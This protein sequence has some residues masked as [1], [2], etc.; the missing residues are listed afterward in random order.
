MISK[1]EWENLNKGN[2]T[3]FY[4]VDKNGDTIQ[5]LTTDRFLGDNLLA[6]SK[7]GIMYSVGLSTSNIFI[8]E[9][10]AINYLKQLEQENGK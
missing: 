7:E 8:S 6:F 5:R 9:Y 10:E 1:K 3:V 2:I 4:R